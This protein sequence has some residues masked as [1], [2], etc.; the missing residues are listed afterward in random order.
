MFSKQYCTVSIFPCKPSVPLA[1]SNTGS[2]AWP[3]TALPHP[4]DS[5]S[6]LDDLWR[7][8]VGAGRALWELTVPELEDAQRGKRWKAE[9]KREALRVPSVSPSHSSQLISSFCLCFVVVLQWQLLVINLLLWGGGGD[10]VL[11]RLR[12]GKEERIKE[13]NKSGVLISRLS[14]YLLVIMAPC[15]WTTSY[16]TACS[17]S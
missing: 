5:S 17:S 13:E 15:Y 1:V 8:L 6:S 4:G 2:R 14:T 16:L 9:A 10:V 3:R 7:P 11:I 12:E